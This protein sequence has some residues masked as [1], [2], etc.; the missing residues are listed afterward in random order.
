VYRVT[1]QATSIYDNN[2]K[3]IVAGNWSPGAPPQL[4]NQILS[5][6]VVDALFD[7]KPSEKDFSGRNQ[8]Q[9]GD[10]LYAVVFRKLSR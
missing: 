7:V 1:I 10:T 3:V 2:W 6:K 8:V 5:V 4:E 9:D